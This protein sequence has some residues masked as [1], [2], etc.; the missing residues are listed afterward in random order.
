MYCASKLLPATGQAREEAA[1]GTRT[2][3]SDVES[4]LARRLLP[5]ETMIR[6]RT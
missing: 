6:G 5:T 3:S 1:S 2:A 4:P